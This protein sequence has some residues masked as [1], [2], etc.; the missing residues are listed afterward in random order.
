MYLETLI[1]SLFSLAF[2]AG[3]S[4]RDSRTKTLVSSFS[5][6]LALMGLGVF[7]YGAIAGDQVISYVFSGMPLFRIDLLGAYFLFLLSA[8]GIGVALYSVYYFEEYHHHGHSLR[9]YISLSVVFLMS[10]VGVIM[11]NEVTTFLVFWE[12]M[13]FSSFL[14][15]VGNPKEENVLFS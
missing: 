13:S 2:L 4:M 15:V 11:A 5:L 1:Y 10:L 6:L 14:L 7:S 3:L 8:V 9:F 12:I